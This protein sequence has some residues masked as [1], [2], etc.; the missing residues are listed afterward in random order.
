[1]NANNG[2]FKPK[3]KIDQNVFNNNCIAKKDNANVELLLFDLLLYLFQIRYKDIP[4]NRYNIVQ[5]GPN[6]QLGG[7]NNGLFKV[8]YHVDTEE[9]VKKDPIMPAN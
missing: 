1:M 4:I 8:I 2:D 6:T 5:T 3:N 9:I 7:L